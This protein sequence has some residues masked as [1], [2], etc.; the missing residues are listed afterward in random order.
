MVWQS[1]RTVL[2]GL[3]VLGLVGCGGLPDGLPGGRKP[4]ERDVL[5]AQIK[6]SVVRIEYLLGGEWEQ[7]AGVIIAG[8]AG[9]CTVATVGHVVKSSELIS[10]WTHDV[11]TVNPGGGF[12]VRAVQPWENG[13]DLAIITFDAPGE[14]CPYPALTLGDSGT[15]QPLDEVYV[16]GFPEGVTR[17]L[18]QQQVVTGQI[19]AVDGDEVE[20]Y[21]ITHTS[22]TAGGMSGGPL[23]NV[24]GEVVAVHGAAEVGFGSAVPIA[25]LRGELTA[26]LAQLP[27]AAEGTAQAFYEQGIAL[28]NEKKYEEALSYFKQAVALDPNYALAWG[29]LGVSLGELEQYENSIASFDKA[30]AI[31]PNFAMAWSNRGVSFEKLE[32]YENAITSF[33]KAIAIN[34]DFATAWYNRGVS[35]EKLEQYENAIASYDKAIEINPDFAAVWSNRGISLHSLGQYENAITS[36]DKAIAINP[37]FADAWSN[38]GISLHSLEQ[39]ENAL[40]SFD[41]AIAINSDY[42]A[43]WSN[44]GVSLHSLEQ[45]ENA[46]A[47]Y[48]KAIAI[49]PDLAETWFNRGN[50]LAALEQY[51]NA[52]ASYD[53]AI[54]INPDLAEARSN[55]GIALA[56]LGRYQEALESVEKAIQLYPNNER[57]Q[58]IRQFILEE[59]N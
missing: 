12:P 23:V 28:F 33:D 4:L 14:G 40:A 32:Q 48:D 15:L 18:Y 56:L 57:Y 20:G 46:L 22:P 34:P 29:H 7:G 49:N 1:A 30:I 55:R 50:S 13:M 26:M 35:F 44:R 51:E 43:A 8:E 27:V 6:P 16:F 31:N 17:A 54:A 45:Y 24:W 21:D 59:L 3:M 5:V 9:L 11:Y 37:D 10:V 41:K 42:A 52:I 25:K 39:Y 38:R 36:F 47:S 58:Q 2:G 19:S 53:K